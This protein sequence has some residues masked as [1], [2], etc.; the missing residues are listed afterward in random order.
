MILSYL[1]PSSFIDD[2]GSGDSNTEGSDGDM[3]GGEDVSM[4]DWQVD[5][6]LWP[7]ET[8]LLLSM[9]WARSKLSD[10]LFLNFCD[11]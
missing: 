9:G 7:K 5:G 4:S 8:Y 3:G 1:C 2:A 10:L 11:G 6:A